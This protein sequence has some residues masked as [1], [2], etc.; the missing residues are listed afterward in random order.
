MAI[1]LLAHSVDE[2]RHRRLAQFRADVFDQPVSPGAAGNFP[3]FDTGSGLR[4]T[5]HQVREGN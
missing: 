4:L 2:L 5:F 1:S 3:A